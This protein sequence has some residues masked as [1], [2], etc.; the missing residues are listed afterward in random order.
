MPVKNMRHEAPMCSEP[1]PRHGVAQTPFLLGHVP[2]MIP[3]RIH[4]DVLICLLEATT[5][6][7]LS[8]GWQWQS[9]PG[10]RLAHSHHHIHHFQLTLDD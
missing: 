3:L 4:N 2:N 10:Q 8:A 7:A 5:G 1:L 9:R 6:T